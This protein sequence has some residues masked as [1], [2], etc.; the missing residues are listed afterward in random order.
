MIARWPGQIKAGT[1]SDHL[2][3][4]WDVFPTFAS[5][6]GAETPAD[7]DGIS[8][9]PTLLGLGEQPEHEFLYWEFHKRG[10]RQAVRRGPWK[11]VRYN[12]K[13]DPDSTVELYNLTNDP[14]E[15]NNVAAEHP[16]EEQELREIMN[17][18]RTPS[19]VFS[20]GQEAF[21]GE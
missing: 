11:A 1:R 12:V 6:A 8:M 17:V 2:S 14:G 19:A 4:F 13:K 18:A 16:Q 21:K 7:I 9:V 20:F 10:G 3:A 5:L 15:Q